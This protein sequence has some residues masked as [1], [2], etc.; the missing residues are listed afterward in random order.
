MLVV[1]AGGEWGGGQMACSG[2]GSGMRTERVRWMGPEQ[3]GV[4]RV[5]AERPDTLRTSH[6]APTR[7]EW[8]LGRGLDGWGRSRGAGQSARR[9]T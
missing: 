9:V 5:H 7:E 3:V 1:V 4:G 2:Q 8:Q 6:A